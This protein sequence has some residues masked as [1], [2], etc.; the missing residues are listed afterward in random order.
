M[1]EFYGWRDDGTKRKRIERGEK[2]QTKKR[3]ECEAN[4]PKVTK[5]EC[6]VKSIHKVFANCG[7]ASGEIQTEQV[8]LSAIP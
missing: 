6:G 4:H 5:S 3:E 1:D 8:C 7:H 2:K